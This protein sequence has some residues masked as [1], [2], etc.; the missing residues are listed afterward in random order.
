M[1]G[2]SRNRESQERKGSEIKVVDGVNIYV[3]GRIEIIYIYIYV[4]ATFF[5]FHNAGFPAI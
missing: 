2:S 4:I 5:F 1:L 3:N